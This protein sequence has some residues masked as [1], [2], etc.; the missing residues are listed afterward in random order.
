MKKK[1]IAL[2]LTTSLCLS[3]LAVPVMADETD[4]AIDGEAA[5]V[6]EEDLPDAEEI[7]VEES[8][9]DAVA[10]GEEVPE[11]E[12]GVENSRLD[13]SEAEVTVGDVPVEEIDEAL[14]EFSG[15][16]ALNGLSDESILSASVT[17]SKKCYRIDIVNGGS[18]ENSF[19]TID[20]VD[21]PKFVPKLTLKLNGK[22]LKNDVDY[23]ITTVDTLRPGCI[24]VIIEGVGN[25]T[26][27][28]AVNLPAYLGWTYAG[29][30]R[31]ATAVEIIKC[32][33]LY[34]DL[35]RIVVVTG[36]KF[37]DALAANAYAG[38]RHSPLL[39]VKP[40]GVPPA[41][42]DFLGTRSSYIKEVVLIG[43][44]LKGAEKQLKKLLPGASFKTIAGKNRYRTADAVTK[45]F[46]E[47]AYEVVDPNGSDKIDGTVFVATGQAAADALS[48]APWSYR[49]AIPVLLVKDG[50]ADAETKKILN[51]FRRV[52]LLGSSSTVSDSNVPS[53][54]EKI[55]LGGKNRWETSRKIAD[56]FLR[57]QNLSG[58]MLLHRVV[59]APGG[60]DDFADALAAG[61]FGALDSPAAVILVNETHANAYKPAY[62]SVYG[63]SASLFVGSAGYKVNGG[64]LYDNLNK[65]IEPVYLDNYKE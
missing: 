25:Y 20:G 3:L 43:G 40:D 58:P 49:E 6:G 24:E 29:K 56:Y 7:A 45:A 22:T 26:G 12:A 34:F 27:Q 47:E 32:R 21:E 51:R 46:I 59:Y 15:E 52:I 64:K 63:Y 54:S 14:D 4:P 1:M 2:L 50:K 30:N 17:A 62:E 42:T 37:P 38:V 39:L 35:S 57:D 61:Q 10:V 11:E 65:S 18:G 5:A 41:V 53:G 31:Y 36:E 33:S 13:I 44:D 23:K 8:A 60:G 28:R 55:R 9:I 16:D 19:G 48:A